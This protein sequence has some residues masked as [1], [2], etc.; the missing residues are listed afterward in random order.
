L[1][2]QTLLF[3]ERAIALDSDRMILYVIQQPWP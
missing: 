1:P 3:F 2:M